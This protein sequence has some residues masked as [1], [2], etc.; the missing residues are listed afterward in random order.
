MAAVDVTN[1]TSNGLTANGDSKEVLEYEKLLRLRADVVANVHPRLSLPSQ[2]SKQGMNLPKGLTPSAS[3]PRRQN[4]V[5]KLSKAVHPTPIPTQP[6]LS[7]PLSSLP[8]PHPLKTPNTRPFQIPAPA[9]SGFDPLFLTKSEVL[10]RA[11]LQQK[12]Q[13]IERVL[14]EQLNQS[15]AVSRQRVFDQEASPNFDAAK[16]LR[17]AQQIVKPINIVENSGTNRNASSSDSFDE[18]TFYSSQM[19]ESTTEEADERGSHERTPWRPMKACK[20]FFEGNCRKG[21]GCTFSHD[22]AF[23]ET[24]EADG[25]QAMDI[26]GVNAD[27]QTTAP[28]GEVLHPAPPNDSNDA[29]KSVMLNRNEQI[30]Q[31]EQQLRN[32][33]SIVFPSA[34]HQRDTYSTHDE[35]AYSPPEA[36]DIVA[37]RQNRRDEIREPEKDRGKNSVGRRA[38]PAAENKSREY[39]RHN[40]NPHSPIASEIRII[41]N[42]ITSPV[43]PQPSRVSPLAVSRVPP[44][45]QGQRVISEKNRPSRGSAGEV[46]NG[47]QSPGAIPQSL[48]SLSNARKRRRVGSHDRGR[49][50]MPRRESQEVRIKEEPVSPPPFADTPNTWQP[51]GR[52]HVSKPVY[53]ETGSP[54]YRDHEPIIY[55][56]RNVDHVPQSYFADE[57][58]PMSPM[59]RRVVSRNAHQ[60]SA[61]EEPSLRRVVSA[62]QIRIPRSPP[63]Q[64]APPQ[65]SST[66]AA[67]QVYIPQRSHNISLQPR[68]SVQPQPISHIERDQSISPVPRARISP[69]IRGPPTMAPPARRIVVDRYGQTYEAPLAFERQNS[70]APVGHPSELIPRYDH[71]VPRSPSFRD[72]RLVNVYDERR[73]FRRGPSPPQYVEYH[74]ASTSRHVFDRESEPVYGE[75]VYVPRNE[76]VRAIDYA[77]PRLAGHTEEVLRPREVLRTASVRPIGGGLYEEPREQIARVQS[78]RPEADG[79]TP[80]ESRRLV[81]PD[82]MP[83][84]RALSRPVAY[85]GL[86]RPK[87]WY[88]TEAQE[89]RY[90]DE[91]GDE[92]VYEAPRTFARRPVLP[93]PRP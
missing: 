24:V 87:Y 83:G 44:V 15:R 89:R 29:Q 73:Y 71:L 56:P 63:G 88:T 36:G 55:Q 59:V 21:N 28:P 53:I 8:P 22:P 20:F 23:K 45:H 76:P 35:P 10:V 77:D 65:P 33:K 2:S 85:A 86:E 68:A 26:D 27:E 61:H 14:K 69:T 50:V 49:Y 66:R 70:A 92:V 5:E 19:N 90:V 41:R 38:P 6:K 80:L 60:I 13:Q 48:N 4:G 39:I 16:V 34:P 62:R 67:S 57:R 42:H 1:R 32:L 30:E 51:R 12:R 7:N 93:L 84:E 54:R 81:L 17:E 79:I 37:V 74:P 9:S 82:S 3:S 31:L 25:H 64:Y 58:R 78:V 46:P 75:E 47:R 11:E 43:A 72:P 52:Q 40:Q 18:K 91:I